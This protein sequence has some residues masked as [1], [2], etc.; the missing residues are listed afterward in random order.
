MS[1]VGGGIDVVRAAEPYRY[2][3][4]VRRTKHQL[5]TDQQSRTQNG[6]SESPLTPGFSYLHHRSSLSGTTCGVSDSSSS[7]HVTG[8]RPST[9]R[10]TR[11]RSMSTDFGGAG[12]SDSRSSS[13]W[14]TWSKRSSVVSSGSTNRPPVALNNSA[15]SGRA[16]AMYNL[17]PSS[18]TTG[19]QTSS[20]FKFSSGF[21]NVPSSSNTVIIMI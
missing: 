7:H 1:V 14:M 2:G 8:D 20:W 19:A 21:G 10:E 18:S 13:P 5:L 9:V 12:G 15:E 17:A 6:G 11:S 4:L 3:S 16:S